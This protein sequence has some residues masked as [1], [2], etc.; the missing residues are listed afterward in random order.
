MM[1]NFLIKNVRL[2]SDCGCAPSTLFCFF[3]REERLNK[4]GRV[5]SRD[6]HRT[7]S[8]EFCGIRLVLIP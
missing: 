2:G 8:A 4:G 1:R 3:Q 6:E 5:I 7:L